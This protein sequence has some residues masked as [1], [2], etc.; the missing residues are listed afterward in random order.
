MNV[1]DITDRQYDSKFFWLVSGSISV[2][3]IGS[4]FVAA[5]YTS[6]S[7]EPDVEA[8]IVQGRSRT[9][10]FSSHLGQKLGFLKVKKS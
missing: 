6:P 5:R 7:Q 9:S 2:V 4:V 8:G 3:V 1:T 10:Y